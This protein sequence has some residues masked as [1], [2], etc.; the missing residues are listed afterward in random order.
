MAKIQTNDFE[1][2]IRNELPS[3]R[4]LEVEQSILESGAQDAI[5]SAILYECDENEDIDDLIGP[6]EEEISEKS[7]NKFD[8]MCTKLG[9][10][11]SVVVND[12]IFDIMNTMNF[13]TEDLAKVTNRYNAIS[14]SHDENVSLKENLVNYY[15]NANSEASASDAEQVVNKLLDGCETLTRKYN[16]ALAG[17]FNFEDEIAAITKDKTT[18]ERFSI[19]TNALALVENLNLGT[20][21]SQTDSK[22]ALE[23]AIDELNHATPEPTEED[24]DA[25]AKLLAEAIEN[26]T[27]LINGIEGARHLFDAAKTDKATAIDFAS[28]MYDDARVKAETALAMWLEYQEGN[29]SSLEVGLA[30]EAVAVG[31]ATAVEEAKVMD[32]IAKGRKTADE[33]IMWLK[34]LG[35]VALICLLGYVAALG[36]AIVGGVAAYALLTLFGTSTFA[37]IATI[38]LII[39]LLWGLANIE[40]KA[41]EYI[42]EKAGEV[43]DFVVEKLRNNIFPRIVETANKFFDW[44]KSKFTAPQTS[45]VVNTNTALS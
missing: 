30:P 4:M 33:A 28:E 38:V 34:I 24:C 16:E 20:F 32:D 45:S 41:G 19:L 29:I 1:K 35:G 7:K 12:Q 21:A 3:E 43:Y 44:L 17:N 18:A 9:Q 13:T 14:S 26:N 8:E 23:K 10:D 27:L 36:A 25:I 15:L 31:A 37:C 42:L 39:P 2:F 5:L 40:V 22:E 6:D 11:A